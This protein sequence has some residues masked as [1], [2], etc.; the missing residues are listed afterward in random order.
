M[1]HQTKANQDVL[2]IHW[3][4]VA[5]GGAADIAVIVPAS[6]FDGG[7]FARYIARPF[8]YLSRTIE[9]TIRACALREGTHAHGG[10]WSLIVVVQKP[11]MVA[12]A[13]GI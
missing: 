3:P 11:G 5:S 10:E 7:A 1:T 6:A 8:E 2:Q 9:H 4:G 13:P 12:V